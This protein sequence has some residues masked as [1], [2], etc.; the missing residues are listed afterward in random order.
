M[1]YSTRVALEDKA[2]RL[3]T[4]YGNRTRVAGL[5]TEVMY[6]TALQ[7]GCPLQFFDVF[8]YAAQKV[9]RQKGEI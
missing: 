2:W 5:E 4:H 1:K 9:W 3:G 7:D 6:Q 8:K